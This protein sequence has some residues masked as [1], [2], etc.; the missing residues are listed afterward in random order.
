MEIQTFQKLLTQKAKEMGFYDCEIYYESG[1]SFEVLIYEKEVSHYE[2][3]SLRGISFR[4][5]Y[6]GKMGYSY[7]E[8]IEEDAIDFLLSE[9]KQNAQIIEEE[10]SEELYAGDEQYPEVNEF[11]E[12][13]EKVTIAEKIKSAKEMETAAKE[14][15]ENV[16]AIDYCVLGY[17]EEEIKIV[18]SKGLDVSFHNNLGTAYVSAIAQ[19]EK[20]IKTGSEYWTDNRWN[21]F[22]PKQIGQVAAQTA[23]NH[24]GACSVSS[25]E[26]KILLE[27][28]VM[29]DLLETFC[30]IF[31][32]ETVQKG[33]S[34]LKE[35][36]QQQVA[37][38]CVTIRDDGILEN[39]AGSIPFDSEGVSCKNKAVVENGILK[40]YLYNL[41]S[42]KRDNTISTGNG[43]R[44]S[45]HSP[46]QT[47][48]TN[49]YIQQGEKS[50]QELIQSMQNGILITEIAGL[51]S[52]ANTI[53]GDFS[54]S[55]EGFLVK[56]GVITHPVEQITI[57]G[58]F[59]EL[60]MNIEE[61]ADDLRFHIP[62]AFGRIGAP[63]V[64]IKKLAISGI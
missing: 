30:I 43:F 61:I 21:T 35:K 18:N 45:Y 5:T 63:T 24:L 54:L 64:F 4:G 7:S 38:F 22:C 37:S 10:T 6:D 31:F 52:G 23:V 57:A 26:Y 25:G 48:C 60:L 20:D 2:N 36:Q 49:F 12:T 33:F 13:L 55:A 58:N 34:L 27:N 3:S 42:A 11:N 19:N 8:K 28:N 44:A 47:T 16:A 56:D 1:K 32:G 15:N 51:H 62:S 53:S 40:T 41:K 50:K 29:A 14:E 39:S 17:E 46:I 59:Y 9:A